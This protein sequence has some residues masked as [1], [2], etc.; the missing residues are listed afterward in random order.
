MTKLHGISITCV[1][2]VSRSGLVA[3]VATV[4]SVGIGGEAGATAGEL[5]PHARK[6]IF[7]DAENNL[8][9]ASQ[10]S[11]HLDAPRYYGGPKSPMWREVR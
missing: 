2:K 3:L 10:Q 5:E 7:R 6:L 1:A 11:T 9:S 8:Q 4:P